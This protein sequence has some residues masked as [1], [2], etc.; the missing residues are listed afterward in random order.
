M[1]AYG[2]TVHAYDFTATRSVFNFL[3]RSPEVARRLHVHLKFLGLSSNE[4]TTTMAEELRKNGHQDATITYLKAR[5]K[6]FSF[7]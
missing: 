6:W 5:M 7:S 1:V 2:C 4:T 3:E